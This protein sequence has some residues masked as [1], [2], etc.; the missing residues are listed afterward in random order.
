[1]K[2]DRR[3]FLK[4]SLAAGAALSSTGTWSAHAAGKG[5][6]PAG[7]PPEIVDT[8]VHLFDWPFR[9]LKYARTGAL[10]SKLRRHRVRQAWAG[11]FEALLAK[12]IAGANARLVEECRERGEGLLVPIGSINPQ[13]PDWQEDLR[14]CDEVHRLRGIRLYPAFHGYSLDHPEFAQLVRLATGRGMLVQ[15]AIEMEDT[16]VQHPL[17]PAPPV[18]P[19]PLVPLVKEVPDARIQ[20]LNSTPLFRF[21]AARALLAA[22]NVWFDIS[23][24]E[25]VGQLGRLIEGRAGAAR[26]GVPVERLCFGSHAPFFPLESAVLKL[27]ES[28]LELPQLQLIMQGNAGH[29]LAPGKPK[30][31]AIATAAGVAT[32][33]AARSPTRFAL[34]FADYGL[35]SR[36][37]LQRLRIWDMHYHGLSSSDGLEAHED[38]MFYVERMG[39]ER[40]ISVDIGGRMTRPQ[41]SRE[42]HDDKQRAVLIEQQDRVSGL[43]PVDPSEPELSCQRMEQWIRNGPCVGIKYYGGNL[44]GV[45]VSDP[46]NDAI[47]R[48]A[49]ELNAIIYIHTWLKVG[50]TPRHPGGGNLPGESTPEDVATLARR[51]PTVNF[52]CGHSGGDWEIGVRMIR[53]QRNVYLE[54]AGSDPH[55]GSVDYAVRELGAE[56]IVWGQHGPSRS[57][58]TELSKVLDADLTPEQRSQI[59]GG[60]LRRLAAPIFK[61]KGYRL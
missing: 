25:G 10:I 21:A 7:A 19:T 61:S 13:L 39:V 52:V 23:G 4:Q 49:Q 50:G 46:K 36:E 26:I 48:L 32:N 59:F 43:V 55:S 47:T 60:N 8:N 18:N 24:I 56:R 17:L 54:F 40:V 20:L 2:M 12:D 41:S 15:I 22:P 6:A 9:R 33:S 30:P 38:M 37:D 27:F 51:F 58:A 16:R 5:A 45:V 1:M 31:A 35:P 3:Q 11:T 28:P 29:M 42:A 53:P 34:K 44:D 57:F 14:R